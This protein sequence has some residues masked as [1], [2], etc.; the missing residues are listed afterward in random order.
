MTG[1]KTSHPD[2]AFSGTS[3]Q[4]KQTRRK[5]DVLP[6]YLDSEALGTLSDINWYLLKG[7]GYPFSFEVRRVYLVREYEHYYIQLLK[8]TFSE[9]ASTITSTHRVYVNR[10]VSHE[11]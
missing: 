5:N 6:F 8:E 1:K 9:P 4:G 11:N 2:L 10:S 3:K 7:H